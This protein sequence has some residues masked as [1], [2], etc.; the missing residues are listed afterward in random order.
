MLDRR[1][2]GRRCW[3]FDRNEIIVIQV[4]P[5]FFKRGV[6]WHRLTHFYEPTW[7]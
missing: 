4:I 1:A 7:K 6:V 5:G 2:L 3:W